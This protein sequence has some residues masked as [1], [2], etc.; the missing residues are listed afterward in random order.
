MAVYEEIGSMCQLGNKMHT[1]A[2]FTHSP[3]APEKQYL[4]G[5]QLSTELLHNLHPR[6]MAGKMRYIYISGICQTPLFR[7]KA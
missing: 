4:H 6:E 5:K 2:L 3:I 1:L 7:V